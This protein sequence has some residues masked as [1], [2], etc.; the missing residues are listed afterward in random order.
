MVDAVVE[1]VVL[2]KLGA[3][4]IIGFLNFGDIFCAEVVEVG[5]VLGVVGEGLEEESV[6]GTVCVSVV[7]FKVGMDV[8]EVDVE[9]EVMMGVCVA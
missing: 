1:G 6:E 4:R 5:I 8:E 7:E 9:L 2:V 3:A